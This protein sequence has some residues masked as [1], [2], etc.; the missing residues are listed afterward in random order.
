MKATVFNKG[1]NDW[2]SPVTVNKKPI[3]QY[4]IWKNMLSRCF[5]PQLKNKF[6]AYIGVSCCETWLHMSNFIDDIQGI[7]N[8]EKRNMGWELDKD[9]L[10]KGNKIYSKENCCFVPKE[11]NCLLTN[12]KGTRGELPV[13]L[14][15]RVKTGKY[16]VR[17]RING[18]EK[19]LGVFD[20]M[21]QAFTVY[22]EARESEI[23]NLANKYKNQLA[24]NVYQSLLDWKIE[25][26]D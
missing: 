22:K 25:I 26:E 13:G 15:L 6:P 11:I 16:Q 24:A 3:W 20:D 12:S 18:V 2:H 5:N 4:Q 8:F 23:R 7:E 14:S 19:Y 21:H 10:K 17:T 9:I 1:F